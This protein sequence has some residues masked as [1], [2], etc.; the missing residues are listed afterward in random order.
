M[1]RHTL[2]ILLAMSVLAAS[3]SATAFSNGGV[4]SV[5]D[6]NADGYVDRE[7]FR[8]MLKHRRIRQELR[9]LWQF[10]AIDKDQ[11]QRISEQEMLDVLQQ[12]IQLRKTLRER[13]KQ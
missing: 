13:K 10:D 6:S 3:A 8:Q 9:H 12:E 11:D 1:K 7:E 4:Y 2:K 5:F